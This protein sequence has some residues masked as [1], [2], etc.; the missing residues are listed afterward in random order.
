MCLLLRF[1]FPT[2]DRVYFH[3]ELTKRAETA[4]ALP[5]CLSLLFFLL[6]H[7]FSSS[8]LKKKK[9]PWRSE[10]QCI[11][12][13]V[14]EAHIRVY[15]LY[16]RCWTINN[17]RANHFCS[18]ILPFSFVLLLL[19][20]QQR[21]WATARDEKGW[22]ILQQKNGVKLHHHIKLVH[23]TFLFFLFSFLPFFRVQCTYTYCALW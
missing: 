7:F 16:T 3:D 10:P 11:S 4:V 8:V 5:P 19:L 9:M 15:Y 18:I 21:C 22:K 20:C 2:L 12:S 23:Q 13:Y 6:F 14:L 17:K 1:S